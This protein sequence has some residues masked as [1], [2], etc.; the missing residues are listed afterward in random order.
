MAMVRV[1]RTA[2]A[3]P[4]VVVA[5]AVAPGVAAATVVVVAMARVAMAA[6]VG[7]V[8]TRAVAVGVAAARVVAVAGVRDKK[9]SLLLRSRARAV[10]RSFGTMADEPAQTPLRTLTSALARAAAVVD[11]VSPTLTK[12]F[13]YGLV[14]LVL[15]LGVR[16]AEPRPRLL[17]LILPM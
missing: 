4:R 14:P 11:S 15:L 9:C 16:S 7:L 1:A 13:H 2:A 8:V 12:I 17:D 6:A 10:A 3:R 5:R